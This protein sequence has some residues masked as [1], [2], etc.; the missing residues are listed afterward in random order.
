MRRSPSLLIA[1]TALLAGTGTATGATPRPEFFAPTS[2]WNRPLNTAQRPHPNSAAIVAELLRQKDAYGG[3]WINIEEYS[4]P[5]YR[6]GKRVPRIRVTA[7]KGRA[8]RKGTTFRWSMVPIP[9]AARAA[10]GTDKHLV[11]WQPSSDTMWEFWAF[12]R[13]GKRSAFAR[14]GARILWA[15]RSP[16][17]VEAPYGATAS[18]LPAAA[19]VITGRDLRRGRID[20]ALAIAIPEPLRERLTLP[21]T[22]TDGWSTNP[23]APMEGQRFRLDPRLNVRA[24][25]LNPL[26][27]MIAVAAQRYGVIVRDKSGAVAFYGEDPQALKGN[28]FRRYIGSRDRK[29]L[30]ATFPWEHLQALPSRQVCCWQ[31]WKWSL[32]RSARGR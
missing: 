18:G 13:T 25:R 31:N 15:S 6:V 7:P 27:K 19:G 32:P 9:A 30:M 4:V 29:A 23:N 17:I 5:I 16:G 22:R 12:R 20:H 8:H 26:V 21:A 1:L 10:D 11:I 3:P 2:V 14:A 24:M 28:P